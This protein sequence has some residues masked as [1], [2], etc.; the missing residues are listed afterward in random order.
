MARELVAGAE[1]L[2]IIFASRRVPSI[3][4]ARVRPRARSLSLGRTTFGSTT[5]PAR[6]FSKPR[7]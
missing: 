7:T 5:G 3:P 6:L 2:S 1:R 4:L